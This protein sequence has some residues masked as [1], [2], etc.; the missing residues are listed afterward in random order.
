MGN[1]TPKPKINKVFS[2]KIWFFKKKKF[3]KKKKEWFFVKK[4]K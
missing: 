3:L 1:F 4:N 2:A